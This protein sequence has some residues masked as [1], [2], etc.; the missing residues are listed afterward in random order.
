MGIVGRIRG[1]GWK[2]GGMASMGIVKIDISSFG[3]PRKK[4]NGK[5]GTREPVSPDSE[6]FSM[7]GVGECAKKR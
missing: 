2:G 3:S 4:N 7:N 5:T 6:R 1:E